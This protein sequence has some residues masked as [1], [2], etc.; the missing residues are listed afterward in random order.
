M[1]IP[2]QGCARWRKTDLA[3]DLASALR[4]SG[5]RSGPQERQ[6]GRLR[7]HYQPIFAAHTGRLAAREALLRW[8]HP[9]LGDISP[10]TIIPIAEASGQIAALGEW[11]LHEACLETAG[12]SL[13]EVTGEKAGAPPRIAIN[14]S[15]LQLGRGGALTRAV[16][17]ALAAS[18]LDP[19]RLEIEITESAIWRGKRPVIEELTGLRKLGMSLALDDFGTGFSSLAHLCL[20]PFDRIKIDRS[21][22]QNLHRT[23]AAAAIVGAVT[24]IARELGISSVAE[25]IETPDQ[26]RFAEQQGCSELQGYLLG[27]PAAPAFSSHAFSPHAAA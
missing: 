16:N 3:A 23:P 10:A 26:L 14:I 22:V 9:R 25:G 19:A 4:R 5:S 20:M 15:P 2:S 7:L 18:K 27:R 1:P 12:W 13:P 17:A 21:F 6:A 11:V 8:E 24:H